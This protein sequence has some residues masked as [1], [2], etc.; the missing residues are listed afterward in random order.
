VFN[1]EVKQLIWLLA[2]EHMHS[3]VNDGHAYSDLGNIGLSH[4]LSY[5]DIWMPRSF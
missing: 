4:E 2:N 1:T 5:H 3:D